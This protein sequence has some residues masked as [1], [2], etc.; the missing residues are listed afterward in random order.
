LVFGGHP[1][2]TPLIHRAA[3][4]VGRGADA[5][6]LYQSVDFRD[7]I[8][9]E[10]LDT[11]A[12]PDVRWVGKPGMGIAE[13]L[14]TLRK[15]MAKNSDAAILIG[16]RTTTNLTPVPGLQEEFRRFLDCHPNGPVYLLG[17]MGGEARRLAEQV[18]RGELTEP[19]GLDRTTRHEVH[20]GHNLDFIGPVIAADMASQ[21]N[22]GHTT[23]LV[24]P[25]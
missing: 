4:V 3:A 6:T 21:L 20:F 8:P 17:L 23:L 9:A 15:A 12:F 10:V 14:T 13:N 22:G 1:S 19:N 16:G 2:I 25:S 5:I 18:E 24:A 11:E 7:E